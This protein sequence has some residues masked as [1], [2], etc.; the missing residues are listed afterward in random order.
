MVRFG[1]D[2]LIE[3]LL[4][5]EHLMVHYGLGGG[6][7]TQYSFVWGGSTQRFKPLPFNDTNFHKN[8]TPF[9]YLEQNCTLFLYLK[10][11]SKFPVIT[12]FPGV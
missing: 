6:G 2:V 8:G 1:P 4:Q 7:T 9:I 5:H 10:D 3:L 12:F 11:K